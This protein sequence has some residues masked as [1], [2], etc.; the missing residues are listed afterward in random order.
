[1]KERYGGIFGAKEK[2]KSKGPARIKMHRA[3]RSIPDPN[4]EGKKSVQFV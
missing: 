2:N 4:K 3:A 1:M